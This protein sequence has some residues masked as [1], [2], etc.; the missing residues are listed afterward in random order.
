MRRMVTVRIRTNYPVYCS[1]YHCSH[2]TAISGDRWPDDVRLSDS[3]P[4]F[5]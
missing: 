3:E 5:T 4:R 2:S 1:D